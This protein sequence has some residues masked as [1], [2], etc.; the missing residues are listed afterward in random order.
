MNGH[1]V[2]SFQPPFICKTSSGGTNAEGWF[3]SSLEST[4]ERGM[5]GCSVSVKR[6]I[7]NAFWLI[8]KDERKRRNDRLSEGGSIFPYIKNMP[9]FLKKMVMFLRNI[10]IFLENIKVFLPTHRATH[11]VA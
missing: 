2:S 4:A 8:C 7:D 1:V 9:S 11:T 3:K 6:L 10:T 5:R